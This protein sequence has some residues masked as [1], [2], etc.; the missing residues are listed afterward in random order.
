MKNKIEHLR[1]LGF[2]VD[3]IT[4][5]LSNETN[6]PS[7]RF[8]AKTLKEL[9][10][11][12]Y[13]YFIIDDFDEMKRKYKTLILSAK[14]SIRKSGSVVVEFAFSP[15]RT[16]ALNENIR[17]IPY[18]SRDLSRMLIMRVNDSKEKLHAKQNSANISFFISRFLDK[19]GN[20][21]TKVELIIPLECFGLSDIDSI[22]D[23]DGQKLFKVL[24]SMNWTLGEIR[25]TDRNGLGDLY[26]VSPD[27]KKFIIEITSEGKT[28]NFSKQIR[29][30]LRQ[31]LAG[32]AFLQS[33]L[34][35]KIDAHNILILWEGLK[36]E[37]VI[38][39]QF[40]EACI[41]NNVNLIF[42]HFDNEWE[43]EVAEKLSK[44]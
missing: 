25:P 32:K 44:L 39:E 41:I 13:S 37:K 40:I 16:L 26:A 30:F 7:H 6:A 35:K 19:R 3:E 18:F 34:S 23:K 33:A 36:T 27:S 2:G 28:M 9:E 1:R 42:T 10:N 17:I 15:L 4:R 5:R 12:L 29:K 20:L 11:G 24:K 38:T 8:I 43:K 22:E 14:A 21:P 31:R